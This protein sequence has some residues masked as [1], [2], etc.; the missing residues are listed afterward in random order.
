M[1]NIVSKTFNHTKAFKY[2]SYLVTK[3]SDHF[4]K[5]EESFGLVESPKPTDNIF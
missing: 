5:C 3:N 4:N 1:A 2:I